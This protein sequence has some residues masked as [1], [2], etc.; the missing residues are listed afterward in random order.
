MLTRRSA[1]A[2]AVAS[3]AAPFA[4]AAAA[5][6]P[7]GPM[8]FMVGFPPG[9]VSD[10]VARLLAPLL[11]QRLQRPV[12]VENRSGAG[13]MIAMTAVASAAPD[14][15]TIGFGTLGML[16]ITRHIV[17]RMPLDPLRDLALLGLI[18]TSPQLFVV[19]PGLAPRSLAELL[20][21]ARA[22]PGR[23]NVG[24]SGNGSIPHLTIELLRERTGVEMT[25]VPYRGV[26]P[27]IT[28]LMSGQI[29]ASIADIPAFLEPVRNG[30]LRAVT[31]AGPARSSLLPDVPTTAEAGLPDFEV[32]NWYGLIAPAATPLAVQQLLNDTLREALADE[33]FSAKLTEF[34]AVAHGT[35]IAEFRR[36]A[37]AE[38]ERWGAVARRVGAKMD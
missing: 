21:Y 5:E 12:V 22:N 13:G 17:D 8:R 25:H 7:P 10:L 34:G 2:L 1:M 4:S 3:W 20:D 35:S 9:G 16:S 38:S 31:L 19:H 29:Q 26:A 14:G 28:D 18:A 30:T 27:V 37:E 15:R 32:E 11:S 36:F 23:V 24:S 6:L 33:G